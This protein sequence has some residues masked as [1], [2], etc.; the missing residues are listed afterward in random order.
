ME[1]IF[2]VGPEVKGKSQIGY[3]R[4][5]DQFTNVLLH[6]INNISI[7][8]LK[9][10]GKTSIAKEVIS[11]VKQE[12]E[13]KVIAIFIDLAKQRSFPDFLVAVRNG[14]ED[15]IMCD[16]ELS[17]VFFQ[18]AI[19]N[20][21]LKKI[22]NVGA[23]T[24]TYRDT[25]DSMF[26][27]I[28]KQDIRVILAIDE[29]DAASDLFKETADFE[30]LRDLSSNRDIGVSLVLISRRQL[31]MIEKKNFNNSTFHGVVQT[32]PINGFE[33]EDLKEYFD[34][35]KEL[36]NIELNEFACERLNYYCGQSPYLF[37][38]FAYDIVD[39]N[40]L[41]REINIDAI[42]RR[43]EIDI[44]NYY[45]SIFACLNN[46]KID[47]EGA[48]GE[49]STVEKL[50]GVIVGPKIGVVENDISV[51]K[52]MGYLYSVNDMYY[53]IS[54][55][56]TNALRRMPLNVDT[57]TSILGLEKKLKSMIRKQIMVN[58]SVE[59]ILYDKWVD[60]FENIG[61]AGT[62]D[63]YDK[64]IADSM[65]EYKCDVDM[66]DVC[67][68][69]VAVS[70][71][72]FYWEEWF[73]PFF[74]NDSWEKWEYKLRLCASARNPI[75]HG[76]EEFLSTEAKASVNEY[77][78][79]I[80]KLLSK[81]NACVDVAT[82]LKRAE[83]IKKS[84]IRRKYYSLSFDNVSVAL[85]GKT[86]KMTAAEQNNKGIKGFISL[87]GKN[88]TCTVGK[89]KWIQKFPDVSLSS[90]LGEEFDVVITLVNE[91]LNTLQIDFA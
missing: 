8:G 18:S 87:D 4:Y 12:S 41:G 63:I 84:N 58:H 36:Y 15:E 43:R 22:N 81:T 55:H 79:T 3:K 24:K 45:K 37:S 59:L 31:Y 14:L 60:I 72:Q 91:T 48:D 13:K 67:S 88:Y 16:D 11:R 50:V 28:T 23:E 6:T 77:C 7:T 83:N 75:A 38:M 74:E 80:I 76:H 35:L 85:Q 27:W 1:N 89:N 42:Y 33:A 86:C 66:L 61:V 54:R 21:Y 70:I 39:D 20:R 49:V 10:F 19:F 65:N 57:W 5:F 34:V 56:F 64:F 53:S 52:K 2:V 51:L 40:A 71:I 78:D 90:H 9:R 25:L 82:E 29:F 44:E 69:D 62:L 47:V 46:D 26:K 30:F 32:Y 68:M 17:N 73:S